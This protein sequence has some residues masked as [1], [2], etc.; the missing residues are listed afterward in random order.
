MLGSFAE[1]CPGYTGIACI[2][3]ISKWALRGE[4]DLNRYAA[5][6]GVARIREADR[7]FAVRDIVALGRERGIY[8]LDNICQEI[9]RR[10]WRE[11]TVI[12]R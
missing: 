11:V 1:Y 5:K 8:G 7:M 12:Y 2:P 6:Y 10:P 4:H 3:G 9:F